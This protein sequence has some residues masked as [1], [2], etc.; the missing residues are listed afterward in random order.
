MELRSF[1]IGSPRKIVAN[2]ILLTHHFLEIDECDDG[3][4]NC[5]DRDC[6][7]TEGSFDCD[8]D[9]CADET[10]NCDT[11]ASCTNVVDRLDH[12][13]C[14][15]NTGYRGD[16]TTDECDGNNQEFLNAKKKKTLI[17]L[18]YRRM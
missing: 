14:E 9:E 10:H 6:I 5:V 12:F 11:D 1:L 18:R 7:N 16:G 15:C 13:E 17:F 8:V 2:S 3:S 4:H